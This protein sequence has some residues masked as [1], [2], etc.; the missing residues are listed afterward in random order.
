MEMEGGDGGGMEGGWRGGGEVLPGPLVVEKPLPGRHIVQ[1][2]E[3]GGFPSNFF[4]GS[5]G[6]TSQTAQI[7]LRANLGLN[8]RVS[9]LFLRVKMAP[10][11]KAKLHEGS[12]CSFPLYGAWE[13]PPSQLELSL[14][15]FRGSLFLLAIEREP[16][17]GRIVGSEITFWLR[18][19]AGWSWSFSRRF[20][21]LHGVSTVPSWFKAC[22]CPAC[23]QT[24]QR[25]A[26][27]PV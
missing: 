27:G 12:T 1:L 13:C 22:G 8:D 26:S 10:T 18:G 16:K 3:S 9:W 11:K 20:W 24:L 25:G 21:G 23:L 2:E 17:G 7:S 5:F 14:S 19:S 4:L 15:W 6:A